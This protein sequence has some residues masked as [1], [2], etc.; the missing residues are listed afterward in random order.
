MSRDHCIQEFGHG[1]GTPKGLGELS[2]LP[3]PGIDLLEQEVP[4]R[5]EACIGTIMAVESVEELA[6]ISEKN[7][8]DPWS[9]GTREP[10]E[11]MDQLHKTR[12]CVL[13]F[14]DDQ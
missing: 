3:G 14:I 11:V 5:Q 10:Q 7:D 1:L 8:A 4:E 12:P 2:A 6:W 13:S 9:V